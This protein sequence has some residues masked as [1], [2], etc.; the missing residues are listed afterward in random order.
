M[1]TLSD[2]AQMAGVS[3]TTVSHVLNGTRHV[4]ESTRARV[5]E[6]VA[7]SAYSP[8]IV[9]RSLVRSKTDSIGLVVPDTAQPGFAGM[10]RGVE[11]IARAAG[12]TL[13]LANSAEDH[14]RQRASVQ[15]LR[16]RRVDGLLIA[17]ISGS[18]MRDLD[19][20]RQQGVP[21]VLIDRLVE[22]N[23]D[24]V[25]VANAEPMRALVRHLVERGH[26]RI[27]IVAGD[28]AV[29][30]LRERLDGY[31]TA[32]ASSGLEVTEAL[33]WAGAATSDEAR[34]QVHERLPIDRPTAV[35]AASLDLSV[36]ALQAIAAHRLRIPDDLA[37]ASFDEFPYADIFE[38]R[39]TTVE[40]PSF[41]IG[42]EAMRLLIRRIETPYAE[43]ETVRLDARIVHRA[44]CG[45]PPGAP[46][47]QEG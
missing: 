45:C 7:S 20:V 1:A 41:E 12:Y 46:F 21:V 31:I 40:Q 18:D 2:V 16:A 34:A 11:H 29:L 14:E 44:S 43:P 19:L 30:T 26:R 6:A 5:L 28:Q 10:V 37:F 39:L 27:A 4:K 22:P 25:G 38:P 8:D 3:T 33:I 17:Q 9:A 32:L 42:S 15:A 24:Q 35:V 23:V 36:G 47:R 13:L